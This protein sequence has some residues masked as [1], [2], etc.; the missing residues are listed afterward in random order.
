[1]NGKTTIYNPADSAFDLAVRA[2]R[3]REVVTTARELLLERLPDTFLG[4][5]NCPFVP[6]PRETATPTPY[7]AYMLDDH[8]HIFN[9]VEL[10][11]CRS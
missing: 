3:T 10:R 11:R 1:M 9:F 8:G 5:P 4:R 7:R 2:A 6:L